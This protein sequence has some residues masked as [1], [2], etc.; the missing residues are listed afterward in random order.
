MEKVIRLT[1]FHFIFVHE[2]KE[3]GYFRK[4]K[5]TPFKYLH[6]II[7]LNKMKSFLKQFFSFTEEC[8]LGK[9]YRDGECMDCMKGYYRNQ[10]TMAK[11]VR[12]ASGLTTYETG[13]EDGHCK[14][15]C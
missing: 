9:E 15:E 8:E 6:C 10:S 12:C 13:N 1:N 14:G 11:C 2:N 5:Y 7:F 3:N 4:L